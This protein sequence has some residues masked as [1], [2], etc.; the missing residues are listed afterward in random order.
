MRGCSLSRI[1]RWEGEGGARAMERERGGENVR[2]S[3][4][5]DGVG[6]KNKKFERSSTVV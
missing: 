2:I 5:F 1:G 6:K 3:L 4:S